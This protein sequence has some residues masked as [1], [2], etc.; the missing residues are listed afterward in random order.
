MKKILIWITLVI[1]FGAIFV[2]FTKDKDI[3]NINKDVAT[4]TIDI[5]NQNIDPAWSSAESNGYN[6]KY[7]EK[8]DTEYVKAVDWPLVLNVDNK[9][10]SCTEGGTSPN[11]RSGKTSK[12]IIDGREFCVTRESEGAAGSIYT[13]YAYAFA[14]ENKTMIATFSLR[15]PQCMNYDDPK[16]TECANE[17]ASFNISPLIARIV[18]TIQPVN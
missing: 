1:I 18:S 5:N 7:P 12:E 14:Y 3:E 13:N 2:Y 17:E 9:T 11:D 15:A 16:Q 8:L 4:N 10:F 6:F